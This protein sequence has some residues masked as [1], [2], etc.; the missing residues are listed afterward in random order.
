MVLK[1]WETVRP[2]PMGREPGSSAKNMLLPT[3]F[4][5]VCQTVLA[6]VGDSKIWGTLPPWN[7]GVADSTVI[8]AS[9]RLFYHAK[10]GHS[11]PNRTN[12]METCQKISDLHAPRLNHLQGAGAYCV[13]PATGCAAFISNTGFPRRISS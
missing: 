4:V 5:T 8:N 3:I 10:F 9:P 7:I 2:R 11:R 13:G 1:I 12:V 6:Y